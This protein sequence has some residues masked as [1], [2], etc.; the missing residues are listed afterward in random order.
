METKER[1]ALR[2]IGIDH[3]LQYKLIPRIHECT[4]HVLENKGDSPCQNDLGLN[5]TGSGKELY[6]MVQSGSS[7]IRQKGRSVKHAETRW[8]A[9][10]HHLVM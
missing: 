7:K 6:A 10:L 2:Q 1:T 5:G 3:C 8:H 4:V 9:V